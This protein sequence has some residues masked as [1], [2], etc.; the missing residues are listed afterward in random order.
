MCLNLRHISAR[1]A[2]LLGAFENEIPC[3]NAPY[4]LFQRGRF[5]IACLLWIAEPVHRIRRPVHSLMKWE[6]G[7]NID[8]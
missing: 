7:E 8:P 1:F 6:M 5:C 2:F 3:S 4:L